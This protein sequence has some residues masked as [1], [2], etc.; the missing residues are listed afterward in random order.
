MAVTIALL[1]WMGLA[2]W[3]EGVAGMLFEADAL[4]F[5]LAVM[6][7]AIAFSI[8]LIR[9]KIN[10]GIYHILP[11]R[12][13]WKSFYIGL[14]SSNFLPTS[15]GGDVVRGALLTRKNV[16]VGYVVICSLLDRVI[17]LIVVLLLCS[18][19]L[20]LVDSDAH[21]FVA[22]QKP[23]TVTVAILVVLIVGM[24]FLQI[25]AKSK[26]IRVHKKLHLLLNKLHEL[27]LVAIKNPMAIMC[28]A[29]LSFM[30]SLSI[31]CCYYFIALCLGI[32]VSFLI[33]Y[34]VVPL[35]FIVSAAPISIGGHGVREGATIFLLSKFNVPAD[36]AIAV[37]SLYLI[38]LFAVTA[39]AVGLFLKE[40]RS[41][42]KQM[43]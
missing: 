34:I 24:L 37:A 7:H 32:E 39:P 4:L 38:V 33:F 3:S 9:W 6:A 30:S 25:I 36:Q 16:P 1:S 21:A 23:L 42:K 26:R 10:L 28:S 22:Q 41:I 13:I 19:A 14:F 40:E 29:A 43:V 35:S 18:T 17:G 27:M 20:F 8:L 15:V 12:D 11:F 5:V 2:A 31:M